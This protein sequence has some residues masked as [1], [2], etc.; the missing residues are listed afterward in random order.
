MDT[1]VR[2]AMRSNWMQLQRNSNQHISNTAVNTSL[3]KQGLH[4][5][6]LFSCCFLA[7]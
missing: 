7:V 3:S 6:L 2:C 1:D 4:V 5:F